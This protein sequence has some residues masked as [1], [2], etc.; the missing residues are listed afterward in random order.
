MYQNEGISIYICKHI[1]ALVVPKVLKKLYNI[2]YSQKTPIHVVESY[3]IKKH[4]AKILYVIPKLLTTIYY[5][6]TVN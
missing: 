2:S 1:L 3:Q 5:T 6:L 4:L